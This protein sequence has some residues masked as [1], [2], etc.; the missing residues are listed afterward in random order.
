M[1][2]LVQFNTL[3]VLLTELD[4]HEWQFND[5]IMSTGGFLPNQTDINS[6]IKW[7]YVLMICDYVLWPVG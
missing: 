5:M 4:H 7:L 2:D 1:H 6:A 3:T